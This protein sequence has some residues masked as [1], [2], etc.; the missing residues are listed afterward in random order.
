MPEN[1]AAEGGFGRDAPSRSD[2]N[3]RGGQREKEEARESFERAM[4]NANRPDRAPVAPSETTTV[5]DDDDDDNTDRSDDRQD[6]AAGPPGIGAPPSLPS[7]TDTTK[8]PDDTENRDNRSVLDRLA[9]ALTAP[10]TDA[11]GNVR[12]TSPIADRIGNHSVNYNIDDLRA[13]PRSS[14]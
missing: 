12:S 7:P 13:C 6:H 2:E 11:E 3:D 1:A 4:D 14:H 10:P 8:E 5:S 9:D